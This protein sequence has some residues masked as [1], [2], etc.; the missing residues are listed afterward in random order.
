LKE[1]VKTV[2]RV[3]KKKCMFKGCGRW[4][5]IFVR[6]YTFLYVRVCSTGLVGGPVGGLLI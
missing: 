2:N 4:R 5:L 3:A 1:V 6:Q